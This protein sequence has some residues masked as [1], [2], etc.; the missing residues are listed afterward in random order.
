MDTNQQHVLDEAIDEIRK[1]TE[2]DT[3][4]LNILVKHIVTLSPADDSIEQAVSDIQELAK[5]R[6]ES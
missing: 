3:D 5:E 2:A 6:A 1:D 4:L